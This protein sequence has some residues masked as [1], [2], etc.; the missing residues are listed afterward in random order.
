MKRKMRVEILERGKGSICN[1]FDIIVIFINPSSLCYSKCQ[2]LFSNR[3]VAPVYICITEQQQQ[4]ENQQDK[5]IILSSLLAHQK[6]E[7]GCFN[8][9]CN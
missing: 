2:R 4:M 5:L 1:V 7:L 6:Y 8:L 3:I 9:F